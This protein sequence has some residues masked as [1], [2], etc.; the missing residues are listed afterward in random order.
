MYSI[1]HN[2][3]FRRFL[4]PLLV[5]RGSLT[6]EEAS[7]KNG[8]GEMANNFTITISKKGA[9]IALGAAVFGAGSALLIDEVFFDNYP[10]YP[11]ASPAN[12]ETPN[13]SMNNSEAN[14]TESAPA[15]SETANNNSAPQAEPATQTQAEPSRI[16]PDAAKQIAVEAAGGQAIDIYPGF[17]AGRDVFY[18]DIRDGVIFKEVYV[19]ALTGEVIKVETGP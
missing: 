2:S 14:A 12:S 10:E 9:A 7:S 6:N 19:D 15:P 3:K 17:E 4:A 16:T 13:S 5:A 8:E 11:Y 18:V 1:S